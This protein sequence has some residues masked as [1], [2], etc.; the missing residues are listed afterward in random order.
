MPPAST[1]PRNHNKQATA[2]N[3]K[4]ITEFKCR[5]S[6]LLPERHQFSNLVLLAEQIITACLLLTAS[7]DSKPRLCVKWW[8]C[9]LLS[10]ALHC[11]TSLPV[12]SCSRSQSPMGSAS[13]GFCHMRCCSSM[14]SSRVTSF[15][16]F[17]N[18]DTCAASP[19]HHAAQPSLRK[20]PWA[21]IH[22]LEKI[23][24]CCL[25]GQFDVLDSSS[26]ILSDKFPS[27]AQS[28]HDSYKVA[29]RLWPGKW[30][31]PCS[32]LRGISCGAPVCSCG[33]HTSKQSA[34]RRILGVVVPPGA[35][36][37]QVSTAMSPFGDCF[38]VMIHDT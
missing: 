13:A 3:L 14:Q 18:A 21:G 8:E 37:N 19:A 4:N 27:A 17:V 29:Q 15:R 35:E 23:Q 34:T 30:A 11:R 32:V 24:V 12:A 25:K 9:S 28:E 36:G 1:K 7:V 38:Y 22:T 16:P 2:H 20:L 10:R 26:R 31:S 33:S 5:T 6:S